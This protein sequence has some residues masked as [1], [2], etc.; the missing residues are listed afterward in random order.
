M[1][2][3]PEIARVRTGPLA[4]NE[5]YGTNGAFMFKAGDGNS[6]LAICSSGEGWE[7]VSVSTPVR[8]PTWNEM[9]QIKDLFWDEED[10]VVQ[11]HPPRSE[12]VDNHPF[13]LHLWRMIG[14]ELPRPPSIM[15]GVTS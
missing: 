15:V 6:I 10:C 1:M 13:C 4:S 3:V 12:Y 2:K 9:C 14:A 11:Y 8:T 7:H 5:S